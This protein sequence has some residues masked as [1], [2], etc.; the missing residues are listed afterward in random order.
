M[1]RRYAQEYPIEIAVDKSIEECI[2]SDVLRDF[3]VKHRQEA[4]QMSILEYDYEGHMKVI[5]EESKED[6]YAEGFKAGE[7]CGEARGE[8]NGITLAKKIFKLNASGKNI[9]EECEVTEEK[10]KFI[11]EE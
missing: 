4:R 3:L 9:A 11:L 8:S 6:G 1:V 7:V 2:Q 10:V 5:R